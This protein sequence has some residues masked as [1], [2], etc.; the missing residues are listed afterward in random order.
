MHSEP[1]KLILPCAWPDAKAAWDRETFPGSAPFQPLA[2]LATGMFGV[3][4][5]LTETGIGW[6]L[7]VL[8]RRPELKC[9]L[10]VAVYP[11]CATQ[12]DD[13]AA[14]LEYQRASSGQVE[15]RVLAWDGFLRRACSWGTG[16]FHRHNW[17]IQLM[18]LMGNVSAFGAPLVGLGGW[19]R[20]EEN[21]YAGPPLDIPKDVDFVNAD[22]HT[23]DHVP[24]TV[25]YAR[26]PDSNGHPQL[27]E[28]GHRS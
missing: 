23:I 20:Y 14:L 1:P 12:Q 24:L 19:K 5:D 26:T 25:R 16:R 8:S 9:R 6:L 2:E 15:F 18:S 13:L 22:D 17:T 4:T 28:S 10:V 3:V 27:V 21:A 7:R 11:A